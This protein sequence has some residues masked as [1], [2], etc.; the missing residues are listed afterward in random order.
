MAI[1]LFQDWRETDF[2]QFIR[3]IGMLAEGM[4]NIPAESAS[5]GSREPVT[6][7]EGKPPAPLSSHGHYF[8]GTSASNSRAIASAPGSGTLSS[9]PS[10]I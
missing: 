10:G 9:R 7:G 8:P 2:D 1:A 3:L 6:H 4:A 5:T